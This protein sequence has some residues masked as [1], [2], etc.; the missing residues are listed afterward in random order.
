MHALGVTE[1]VE[2]NSATKALGSWYPTENA[3]SFTLH[4]ATSNSTPFI[5]LSCL[6]QDSK[7]IPTSRRKILSKFR[8]LTPAPAHITANFSPTAGFATPSLP[9]YSPLPASLSPPPL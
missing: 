1:K 6:R 2:R 3:T 9:P 7:S 4:P 8:T 5:S